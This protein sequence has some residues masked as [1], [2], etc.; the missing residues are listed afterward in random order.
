MPRVW[1]RTARYLNDNDADTIA[2]L[3][4]I[5]LNE[6]LDLVNEMDNLNEHFLEASELDELTVSQEEWAQTQALA[7][8]C[9]AEI[10]YHQSLLPQFKTPDNSSSKA[11]LWKQL[12]QRLKHYN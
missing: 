6:K 3:Q 10:Q 11:Y 12:V 7:E 5:K 4:A 1:L 9:N 8:K 2:A